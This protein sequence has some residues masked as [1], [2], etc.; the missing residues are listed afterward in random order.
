[1]VGPGAFFIRPSGIAAL[2]AVAI[3]IQPFIQLLIS[4][5][6]ARQEEEDGGRTRHVVGG[7]NKLM[8]ID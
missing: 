6:L 8:P 3:P 1:M 4:A 2:T 7:N 5:A